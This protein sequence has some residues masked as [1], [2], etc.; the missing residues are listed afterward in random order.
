MLNPSPN[1]SK[2]SNYLIPYPLEPRKE[3]I[4]KAIIEYFIQTARPVGSK[5]IIINYH[6]DV[7]PATVRNDMVFL[8]KAGYIFQPHTSAGRVPTDSGYR[9]YV[10]K[11]VDKN[12]I[13]QKALE[14]LKHIQKQYQMQ[15]YKEK[16]YDAVSLMSHTIDNIC[17]ATLPGKKR[18]FYLGIAQ[19]LKQ[20][21]FLEE[22]M[23][24]SQVMEVL[25]EG[26]HFIN[27]LDQLDIS[28]E[29]RIFIGKENLVKQIESCSMIVCRYNLPE[30]SGYIGIL[31]PTRMHYAFNSV[32]VEE[33]KTMLEN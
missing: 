10:D 9:M 7:S 29:A 14:H 21:E 3:Q 13:R 2:L 16:V 23:R 17:F 1:N 27:T 31:G 4:F 8:E 12:E 30:Y 20:P 28:N 18:T 24:A 11:L 5:S 19:T 22:P 15:K 33:I 26:D 32:I 25:E 6:M